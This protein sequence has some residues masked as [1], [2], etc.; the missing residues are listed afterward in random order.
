MSL[1]STKQMSGV[2]ADHNNRKE[3]PCT[4][5]LYNFG[6]K[7]GEGISNV[8]SKDN[9]VKLELGIDSYLL[10]VHLLGLIA[11]ISSCSNTQRPRVISLT[12]H[13]NSTRILVVYEE[14]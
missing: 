4:C 11:S 10:S 3:R 9:T 1:I 7:P 6:S 13:Q 12:Y 5:R 14:E 8:T 2:L